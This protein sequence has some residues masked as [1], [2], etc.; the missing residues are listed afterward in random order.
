MSFIIHWNLMKNNDNGMKLQHKQS[1]SV[2]HEMMMEI[3]TTMR[4]KSPATHERSACR[5]VACNRQQCNRETIAQTAGNRSIAEGAAH[6]RN[7]TAAEGIPRL[8]F[9]VE[10]L[11]G[12]TRPDASNIAFETRT[13][14]SANWVAGFSVKELGDDCAARRA[15]R[16]IFCA[17]FGGF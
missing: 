5:V 14:S 11:F 3:K 6:R 2:I 8:M 9:V 15:L 10:C 7:Q 12:S 1:S 17:R 13:K 4:K 16:D